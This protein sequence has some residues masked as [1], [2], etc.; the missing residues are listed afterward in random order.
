MKKYLRKLVHRLLTHPRLR[1][2][3]YRSVV[4]DNQ[5]M[6]R[7][8]DDHII[9]CDPS[10]FIGRLVIEKGDW[11]RRVTDQIIDRIEERRSDTQ[12][13]A[14][15]EIGANIGT[16]SV[17]AGKR[18]VFTQLICIEPDPL[19]QRL[20]EINLR[21][22]GL[23]DIS[24]VIGVGVSDSSSTMSLHR[25]PGNSGGASLMPELEN[26]AEGSEDLLRSSSH[27]DVP[28]LSGPDLIAEIGLKPID[29]E[30]IWVDVEG[31]ELRVL[32]SLLPELQHSVPV[33]FEYKP[34][35]H[36]PDARAEF[37]DMIFG[38]Y[39]SVTEILRNGD[40]VTLD[41]AGFQKISQETDILLL[42]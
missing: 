1:A 10:D 14:W 4:D 15:L 38:N 25:A 19:N 12:R 8:N 35:F 29:I 22:N 6:V 31:F 34:F 26:R 2:A 11:S 21:S 28:V 7:L 39:A 32:S 36:K 17:Y 42:P 37:E 40:E 16:Q 9:V 33:F 30:F 23:Q 27:V 18:D 20:L 41:R 13:G 24:R 5:L 3:V